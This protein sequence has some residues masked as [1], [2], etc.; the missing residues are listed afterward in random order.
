MKVFSLKQQF[1]VQLLIAL[2]SLTGVGATA[3]EPARKPNVLF[4]IS[5][6]L[7]SRITPAG[8]AGMKLELEL[9]RT[10]NPSLLHCP[11]RSRRANEMRFTGSETRVTAQRRC[12]SALCS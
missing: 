2:G 1:I 9:A 7:S 3:A 10:P 5:D 8:Y 11:H 12:F 4:I 6:D